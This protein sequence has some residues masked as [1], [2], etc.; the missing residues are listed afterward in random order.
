MPEAKYARNGDVERISLGVP[1]TDG[2]AEPVG[3]CL[4]VEGIPMCLSSTIA[5]VAGP[6]FLGAQSTS[7]QFSPI[8]DVA[9][10]SRNGALE[11]RLQVLTGV[12]RDFD[13]SADRS[14]RG[15]GTVPDHAGVHGVD[16]RV[17]AC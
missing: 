11:H 8:A 4:A 10:L 7:C 5:N 9:S 1:A 17:P 2:S 16:L 15:L 6:A 12:H 13:L 14:L 3:V